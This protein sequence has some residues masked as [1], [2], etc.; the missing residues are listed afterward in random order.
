MNP[1]WKIKRSK[2]ILEYYGTWDNVRNHLSIDPST[3]IKSIN[4]PQ[5][6]MDI[7]ARDPECHPPKK[8]SWLGTFTS[9][10]NYTF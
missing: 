1:S 4:L 5:S 2:H 8:S 6:V 7:I 9:F 3:N 10:K